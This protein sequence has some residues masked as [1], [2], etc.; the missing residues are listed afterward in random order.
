M[1]IAYT[2][3]IAVAV[4]GLAVNLICAWLL[5]EQHHHHHAEDKITRTATTTGT[6]ISGQPICTCCRRADLG[7]AIGGLI[8]AL[9]FTWPWINA[10]AGLVG[11]CVIAT[12][13]YGLIRDFGQVLLDVVPDG[14]P[15]VIRK[16]L[17]LMATESQTCTS[18]RS[19]Q[20]S[21]RHRHHRH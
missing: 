17:R 7:P 5:R 1:P 18:G 20:A 6:T 12:W 4:V 21:R 8:V 14:S 2:E 13:S 19:V 15:G 16:R 10:V 11:A 9:W 3:A